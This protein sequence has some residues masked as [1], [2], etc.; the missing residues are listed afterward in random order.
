MLEHIG[1]RRP[2]KRIED[3][4]R[5]TLQARQGLTRDLGGDGCTASITDQLIG[6]LPE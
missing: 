1:Q 3:S 4:V 5:R 6:N 2:A